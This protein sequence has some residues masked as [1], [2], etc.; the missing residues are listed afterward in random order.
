MEITEE[1]EGSN[2]KNNL[3]ENMMCFLG[4]VKIDFKSGKYKWEV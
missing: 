2:R 4:H 3:E 1:W